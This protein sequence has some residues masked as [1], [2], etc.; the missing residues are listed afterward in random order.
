MGEDA[1]ADDSPGEVKINKSGRA[2]VCTDQIAVITIFLRILPL[3][4][5][6]L[7]FT[8][9]INSLFVGK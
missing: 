4:E 7:E 6:P 1:T 9:L 2:L 3:S 8:L 5:T